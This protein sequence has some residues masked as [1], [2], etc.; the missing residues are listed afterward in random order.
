[1]QE[2]KDVLG[3]ETLYR[4]NSEGEVYSK[5]SGRIIKQGVSHKG[6]CVVS[7]KIGGRAGVCK[8]LRVH[9]MVAETFIPNPENKPFVNH[10]DGVK[11]NNSV[12]NLEWVT[13]KENT[14]HAI[15][16]PL[17]NHFEVSKL[18]ISRRR[19]TDEQVRFIRLNATLEAT[20]RKSIREL[21]SI[22]QISHSTICDIVNLKAYL[23]VI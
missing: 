22:L 1:M 13:A 4:V 15:N 6:Y 9:R 16:H 23:Y 20:E 7:T 19:L 3:Y 14:K 21:A 12:S 17:I 18:A 11:T 2:W 5:R 10:I 8:M